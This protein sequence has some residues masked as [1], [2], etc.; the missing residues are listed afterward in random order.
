MPG[1]WEFYIVFDTFI[2]AFVPGSSG[3]ISSIQPFRLAA[4]TM[5][6]VATTT[7]VVAI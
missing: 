1:A 7:F 4:H 2:L 6:R 3:P 5:Q